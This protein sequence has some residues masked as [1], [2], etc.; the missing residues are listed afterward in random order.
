MTLRTSSA[1]RD[2]MR[3]TNEALVVGVIHDR[4]PVSRADI[5]RDTGLSPATITGITAALIRDGIVVE[6]SAGHSTGGRRPI[7]LAIDRSAASALGIKLTENSAVIALT[8]LGADLIDQRDVSFTAGSSPEVVAAAL[9]EG[10]AA[11]RAEHSDRQVVGLGVGMAGVIDREGGRCRFTPFFPWRDVPLRDLLA[12]AAGLPVIIENDVNALTVAE[13]W[14][15][16]GASTTEYLVLTIGRG[17]GMGIMIHGALYRGSRDGAGEFGHITVDPDGPLCPCGKRGCVEAYAGER[18][19]EQA[20]RDVTG[21]DISL[22]EA[23]TRARA[24]DEALAGVFAD[25]GRVLGLALSGVVSVLNPGLLILGGEGSRFIDLL[26][27]TLTEALGKH[28]FDDFAADMRIVVEPWGDDAW[29]R[30]AAALVLD[31]FFH[32]RGTRVAWG[33]IGPIDT[34]RSSPGQVVR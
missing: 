11:I 12:E 6:E 10:I 15:G 19:I 13:R 4:G 22:D 16:E 17:V 20:A 8:D 7:L 29:A 32:P 33:R 5:A 26:L 1:N 27:P 34:S 21:R 28:A 9:G 23:I 3:R 2:Q 31:D 25:A 18:A 14:F 30:G 24:G